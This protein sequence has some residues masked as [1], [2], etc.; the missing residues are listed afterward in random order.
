MCKLYLLSI[1]SFI[2]L[3]CS[4]SKEIKSLYSS[5]EIDRL[6]SLGTN[7][8]MQYP[9]TECGLKTFRVKNIDI[10]DRLSRLYISDISI[11]YFHD[12]LNPNEFFYGNS[13]QLP[14]SC[15][16]FSKEGPLDSKARVSST[17]LFYFFGKIKPLD[18]HFS[19]YKPIREKT[20]K[21]SDSTWLYKSF[22]QI[23]MIE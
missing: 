8:K 19:T 3:S 7:I 14:D 5:N 1:L 6:V 13:S 23:I 22:H 18:F 17:L 2:L 10:K 4:T 9:K 11:K 16:I 20:I 15:I 21:I 12:T